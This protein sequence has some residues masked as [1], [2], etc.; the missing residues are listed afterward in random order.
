[1][2]NLHNQ[3]NSTQSQQEQAEKKMPVRIEYFL[4]HCYENKG[5]FDILSS[6][7]MIDGFDGDA[8]SEQF[9]KDEAQIDEI[10]YD[11]REWLGIDYSSKENETLLRII[12]AYEQV[13]FRAGFR[14]AQELLK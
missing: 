8:V 4:K 10:L 2:E 11:F 12:L 3:Q 14:S 5:M 9:R 6:A 13:A 1:M 7:I